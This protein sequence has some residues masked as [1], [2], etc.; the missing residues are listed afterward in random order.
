MWATAQLLA[1]TEGVADGAM[2]LNVAPETGGAEYHRV[3]MVVT[4]PDGDSVMTGVGYEEA[5]P[6]Y[7]SSNF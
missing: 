3:A 1:K 6:A 4:V 7:S 2:Y 5:I